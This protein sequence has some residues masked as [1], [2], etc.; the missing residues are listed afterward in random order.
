LGYRFYNAEIDQNLRQNPW[1]TQDSTGS[2]T[3]FSLYKVFTPGIH[4][5]PMAYL[6]NSWH[7]YKNI[8]KGVCLVQS[9]HHH[10]LIEMPHVLAII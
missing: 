8:N 4:F 9:V 10:H 6:F 3:D 1:D 5:T 2:Y 7:Y